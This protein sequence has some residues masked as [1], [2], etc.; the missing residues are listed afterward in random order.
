MTD[1]GPPVY[2][3]IGAW[4]PAKPV[5]YNHALG[6]TER[7]LSAYD[8]D[9]DG[10]PVVPDESEWAAADLRARLASGAPRL[11]VTGRLVGEG[12]D[13]EPLLADVVVVGEWTPPEG[14]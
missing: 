6:E 12:H 11:L 9:A 1:A 5:S 3:R 14:G 8:L 4:D 7:G 2:L 13:G 10:R